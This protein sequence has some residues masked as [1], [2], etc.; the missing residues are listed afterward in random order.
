MSD[1][2]NCRKFCTDLGATLHILF[3]NFISFA[4]V[5][6]E[7]FRVITNGGGILPCKNGGGHS[8]KL[9][10]LIMINQKHYVCNQVCFQTYYVMNCNMNT[11]LT[12]ILLLNIAC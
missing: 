1:E 7:T 9:L 11:T 6:L 10:I 2:S 3:D 4:I 12:S 5:F 8:K